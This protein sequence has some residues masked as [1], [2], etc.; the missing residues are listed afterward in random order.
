M[1]ALLRGLIAL[2]ALAASSA[3][4]A[5]YDPDADRFAL[6]QSATLC[7]STTVDATGLPLAPEKV[8]AIT[9]GL[10]EGLRLSRLASD[11][12]RSLDAGAKRRGGELDAGVKASSEAKIKELS[13]PI[14][15]ERVRWRKLS[16]DRE[17]L[18]KKVDA[19]S[20]EE[21]KPLQP[22]LEKAADAL[23]STSEA[24]KPLEDSVKIM[25]EQAL[26][27][28]AI[29]QEALGPLDEVAGNA[30]AVSLRADELPAPLAEAKAR[31]G[32]L[33]QE[34]RDAARSRAWEKL[35][36]L[37]GVT[38]L[39]FEAADRACNRADDLRR[40][41]APYQEAADAFDAA[42]RTAGA[43]PAAAKPLLDEAQK[44]LARVRERLK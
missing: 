11:A 13:D 43:G 2:A 25:G 34:P 33:G 3:S 5:R 15:A 7:Y 27:L 31:L 14:A 39:L 10:D 44:T 12:A 38:R 1:T 32:A 30:A 41:S 16:A 28:K 36:L 23:Q 17:D 40:V 35:E 19:L 42:R 8:P 9:A 26:A 21:R 20:E 24:L 18:K 29:R 37:R 4:A 22:L 6:R